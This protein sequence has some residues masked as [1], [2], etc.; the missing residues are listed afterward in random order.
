MHVLRMTESQ[1]SR[2][3]HHLLDGSGLEAVAVGLCGHVT[4]G[5]RSVFALHRIIEIPADECIRDRD[6]VTWRTARI[7]ALLAEARES[8][9]ALLKIHSHPGG[10]R[11]FSEQDDR[12]D[13]DLFN[14]IGLKVVGEHVSAIML[15]DG[16]IFG[17]RVGIGGP[18]GKLDRVSVVGDDLVIWSS[19]ERPEPS[20]FDVRHR[21]MFGGR[22]T[23]LLRQLSVG[24]VGVS[25]SGSPTIEMLVRL[26]VGRIVLIEPD[27][28]EAKNLNRIYGATRADAE[29][30]VN[31][32]VMM[33]RHIGRVGLGTEVEIVE[34]HLDDP[35]ALA[36]LATCDVLFGCM[37]SVEGRDTL[38][39]VATFFSLPYLDLGVRIDADGKGG[40]ESVSG[41]V[42]YVQPGG[43]SLRSRGVYT[44]EELHA[45]VL[46]RTD[47]LFYEDQV[48][49]G[50]IRGINVD[51][52]AVISV[53][54]LIA[55]T[56]VNELLARLHPFRTRPNSDFAIQRLSVSHGRIILRPDGEPD[57]SLAAHV[58]RGSVN[59]PLLL[60]RLGGSA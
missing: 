44:D 58:G 11:A 18:R 20:T 7:K 8:G 35:E 2:L 50:Y 14:A 49:R 55:S 15:P 4:C 52:P 9:M 28:V 26:G 54:S 29:A 40:V 23:A 43:S 16:S 3:E 48:R 53:N 19:A 46:R 17:R 27:H 31:K 41:V 33:E 39:R 10:Y 13:L 24:V 59:P 37:D 6:R 32:A 1:R 57:Q 60:P 12:S 38:N 34:G 22:T 36:L 5:N 56:A 21:Q 47:P 51:R 25:G 45:D 30:E 42:H